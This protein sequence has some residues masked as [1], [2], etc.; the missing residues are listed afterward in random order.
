MFV[1]V[2]VLPGRDHK[3]AAPNRDAALPSRYRKEAVPNRDAV[4]LS[5]DGVLP[6]RGRRERYLMFLPNRGVWMER[7]REGLPLGKLNEAWSHARKRKRLD[8]SLY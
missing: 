6:S 3:E 7:G 2:A 1:T 4:L 5:R 8:W